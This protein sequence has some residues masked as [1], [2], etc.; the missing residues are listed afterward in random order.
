MQIDQKYKQS[1]KL[2]LSNNLKIFFINV[3]VKFHKLI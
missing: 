1:L 3:Y 2:N